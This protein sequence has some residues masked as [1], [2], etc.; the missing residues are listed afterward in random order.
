MPFKPFRNTSLLS[1]NGNSPT[2]ELRLGL[3]HIDIHFHN[4]MSIFRF[5]FGLVALIYWIRSLEKKANS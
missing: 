5:A 2:T 3:F 1:G 4:V